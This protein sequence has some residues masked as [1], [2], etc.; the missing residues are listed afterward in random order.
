[1]ACRK[2]IDHSHR[3]MSSSFFANPAVT[4]A[5]GFTSTF[6]GIA[7][8]HVPASLFQQLLGAAIAMFAA[9]ALFGAAA[10]IEEAATESSRGH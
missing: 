1:M 9:T 6:A 4:L 7:M 2:V 3:F 8:N 5:R 10:K